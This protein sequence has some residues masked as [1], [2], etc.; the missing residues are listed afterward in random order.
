MY[1]INHKF[2]H[3]WAPRLIPPEGK[4]G[5]G[6]AIE[7]KNIED[8]LA[9]LNPVLTFTPAGKTYTCWPSGHGR[10]LTWNG[11]DGTAL[12]GVGAQVRNRREGAASA[13]AALIPGQQGKLVPDVDEELGSDGRTA[14]QQP[15]QVIDQGGGQD[16]ARPHPRVPEG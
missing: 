13:G 4:V 3:E 12:A 7:R 5:E 2:K 16:Q 6:R 1:S 11:S 15:E 14:R 10:N 8:S 9:N